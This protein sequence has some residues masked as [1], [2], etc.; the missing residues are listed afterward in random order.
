MNGSRL[1]AR[2]ALTIAIPIANALEA[3]HQARIV[4]RD[5]KPGNIFLTSQGIVKVMDFGLAKVHRPVVPEAGGAT[6]ITFVTSPGTMLGTM[7]YMP[8]EQIRGE[9]IVGRADIYSLGVMIHE[10]CTGTL[11]I[12]GV[13]SDALPVELIPLLAKMIAPDRALRYASAAAAQ[14]AMEIIVA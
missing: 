12:Q 1:S 2:Q 8:P 13:V 7:A 4:H 9:T 11:P 10:L 3:A 5:I 6:V 14:R